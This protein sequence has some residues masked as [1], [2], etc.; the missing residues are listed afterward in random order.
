VD[1]Q[2][3]VIRGATELVPH[4]V[5]TPQTLFLNLFVLVHFSFA[6]APIRES[7]E[8]LGR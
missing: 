7:R 8:V 2:T 4:V 6:L 1:R 3:R 5:A